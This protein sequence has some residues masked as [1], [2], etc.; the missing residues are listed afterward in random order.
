MQV[1]PSITIEE[2]GSRTLARYHTIEDRGADREKL[3]KDED[4]LFLPILSSHLNILYRF[5]SRKYDDVLN[6]NIS[7]S[8]DK[9][10]ID[11]FVSKIRF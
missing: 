4:R 5:N 11:L 2:M 8:F 6:T 3:S 10:L 7:I 1:L 9:N